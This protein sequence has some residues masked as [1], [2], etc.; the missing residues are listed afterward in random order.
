MGIA[1]PTRRQGKCCRLD[2]DVFP[3]HSQPAK[4]RAAVHGHAAWPY[5]PLT[6]RALR[7]M[8]TDRLLGGPPLSGGMLSATL[9]AG[10]KLAGEYWKVIERKARVLLLIE[11]D[12]NVWIRF[13]FG[14]AGLLRKK[15]SISYPQ[16][17]SW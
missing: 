14:I 17:T 13:R 16:A 4:D 3:H 8:Y 12:G 6:G 5:S 10:R 1:Y 7:V 2:S 11:R 15:N 9:G